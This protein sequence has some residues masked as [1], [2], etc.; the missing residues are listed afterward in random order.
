[1]GKSLIRCDVAHLFACAASERTSTC[2]QDEP[3]N[4][5]GRAAAKTLR[6]RR[7]LRVDGNDLTRPCGLRHQ[8]TAAAERFL[9]SQRENRPGSGGGER[10]RLSGR[11]CNP[12][13]DDIT[14]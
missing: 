3:V 12:V 5:A 14:R 10:R 6:Q 11:A 8:R 1:M 7:M 9:V 13:E 2:C 4:L